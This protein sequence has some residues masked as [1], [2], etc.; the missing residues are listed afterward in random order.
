MTR[1]IF[2]PKIVIFTVLL[3][4]SALFFPHASEA[5]RRKPLHTGKDVRGLTFEEFWSKAREETSQWGGNRLRVR[6]IASLSVIGFDARNGRSPAWEAQFVRCNRDRAPAVGGEEGAPVRSCV[7]RTITVRLI[8]TGVTGTTTGLQVSKEAH[9]RGPAIPVE[10]IM[11]TPRKAEDTANSY[12]QHNPVETDAYAYELKYDQRKDIPV[13]AIKR[14]CGYK[15]KAEGRC[16][17]G[18]HWIVKVN[19]EPGDVIVAKKKKKKEKPSKPQAE[20][21]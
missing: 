6:R 9:F 21:Q 19:A 14:T 3:A 8:E 4:A 13:W 20:K 16:I 15:G 5:A 17:Q 10:R 1:N 11:V 12:R 7:G 2:W 18:D